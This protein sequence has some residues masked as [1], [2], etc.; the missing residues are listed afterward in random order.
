MKKGVL[1]FLNIV[2]GALTSLFGFGVVLALSTGQADVA[3]PYVV[4]FVI[5]LVPFLICLMKYRSIKHKEIAKK[6]QSYTRETRE[7]R[8]KKI[9]MLQ[10]FKP[11]KEVDKYLAIDEVHKSF[12]IGL[13]V[14][15]YSQLLSFELLENDYTVT[16][17]GLGRAV[18]GGIL[19]GGVGAIVGASTGGKVSSGVCESMKLRV[20]LRNS[21]I[22]DVYIRF[23]DRSTS[24]LSS[25]YK[26]A[27]RYAQSCISA[28]EIICDYN[29][30]NQNDNNKSIKTNSDADEIL[31]FK[32][33]LDAGVITR[34]EFDA[35]KK[36]IL[37]LK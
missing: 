28:F 1:L 12:K 17:G 33:L 37:N 29:N 13:N 9:S 30:K 31:K 14:F 24:T 18:A 23:I 36:Q 22:D 16:S 4:M 7:D 19:F 21:H 27:Q 15:D 34:A 2:L 25:S 35:K 6:A 11:T 10:T 3:P 8:A 32:K 20:T 5:L 26:N